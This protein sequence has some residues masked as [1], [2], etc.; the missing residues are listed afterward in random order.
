MRCKGEIARKSKAQLLKKFWQIENWLYGG[1]KEAPDIRCHS[2]TAVVIR[3]PQTCCSVY[4]GRRPQRY[5]AGTMMIVERAVIDGRFC[6][7]YT[8]RDCIEKSLVEL[9]L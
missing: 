3:Y 7:C 5:P 2:T 8:C 1:D 6:S 9:E 4:H